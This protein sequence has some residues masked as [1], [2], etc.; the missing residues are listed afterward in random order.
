MKAAKTIEVVIVKKL[1]KIRLYALL[2]V[3]QNL[4]YVNKK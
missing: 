3:L 1:R 4:L 2:L